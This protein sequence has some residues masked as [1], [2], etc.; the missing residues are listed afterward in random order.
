MKCWFYFSSG[1]KGLRC[2]IP[3]KLTGDSMLLI[4]DLYYSNKLHLFFTL[5]PEMSLALIK[6]HRGNVCWTDL[7]NIIKQKYS[8]VFSISP[9]VCNISILSFSKGTGRN[10]LWG[11]E[12]Q[13][14]LKWHTNKVSSDLL[15]QLYKGR[16][17]CHL[18]HSSASAK[19]WD[20]NLGL[21]A[22]HRHHVLVYIILF[23]AFWG[24]CCQLINSA[25]QFLWIN[26]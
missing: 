1:E 8:W 12:S 11:A 22:H 14:S 17:F 7:A 19:I 2:C 9:I 23:L 4:Q 5:D 3:N 20:A 21:G 15:V 18:T 26:C 16:N 10:I 25:F 24:L 13:L 6:W